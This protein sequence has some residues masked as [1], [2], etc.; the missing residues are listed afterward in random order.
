[1]AESLKLKVEKRSGS[2]TGKAREVRR[3]GQIPAV[4]YGHGREPESLSLPKAEFDKM[5]SGIAGSAV[6]ELKLGSKKMRALIREVQRHPT[7][8]DVLHVD[9]LEVHAGEKLTVNTPIHLVGS[10]E[11]VRTQGG[12]LDQIMRE[13]EI[14]VLPKDLPEFVEV[15]VTN[16][17]VG[18]SV[19]VRD[20]QVANAEI[21]DD[22]DATVCTV[23]PPRVE[24]EPVPVPEEEEEE[25]LEPELIRKPK[26]EDEGVES[27]S[28]RGESTGQRE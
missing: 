1:M 2:G 19:H 23:V 12:V 9:F 15:D 26:A 24:I 7:R 3:Q 27:E 16:L 14:R 17:T 10:A 21:L 11:G 25:L 22:P 13:L 28:G 6:I 5:L 20:I 4:I 8:L 18:H